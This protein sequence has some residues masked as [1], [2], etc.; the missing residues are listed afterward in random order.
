MSVSNT[1]N[2]GED[3]SPSSQHISVAFDKFLKEYCNGD[4]TYFNRIISI[5]NSS[6]SIPLISSTL[7]S[8]ELP[9]CSDISSTIGLNSNSMST[10]RSM[11]KEKIEFNQF[12][13]AVFRGNED[14]AINFLYNF[15]LVSKFQGKEE[16]D[17]IIESV[18]KTGAIS[19][20][21]CCRIFHIGPV[22]YSSIRQ[23]AQGD[24]YLK[25]QRHNNETSDQFFR[26][27]EKCCPSVRSLACGHPLIFYSNIPRQ[28]TSWNSLFEHYISFEDNGEVP[29]LKYSTFFNYMKAL[30]PNCIVCQVKNPSCSTCVNIRPSN[31][32]VPNYNSTCKQVLYQKFE[33]KRKYFLSKISDGDSLVDGNHG[34]LAN[35]DFGNTDGSAIKGVVTEKGPRKRSRECITAGYSDQKPSNCPI[36]TTSLRRCQGSFKGFESFSRSNCRFSFPWRKYSCSFDTCGFCLQITTENMNQVAHSVFNDSYPQLGSLLFRLHNGQIGS[37]SAKKELES[38]LGSILSLEDSSSHQPIRQH[39][40]SDIDEAMNLLRI[41]LPSDVAEKE[42]VDNNQKKLFVYKLSAMEISLCKSNACG[43]SSQN[44]VEVSRF[45]LEGDLSKISE[46]NWLLKAL[47]LGLSEVENRCL[48]CDGDVVRSYQNFVLPIV[49][50][51]NQ[52][53]YVFRT[54]KERFQGES[55]QDQILIAGTEYRLS[56]CAYIKDLNHFVGI[57]RDFKD[58]ELFYFDGMESSGCMEKLSITLFPFCDIPGIENTIIISAYYIRIDMYVNNI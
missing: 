27:V 5:P 33:E 58:G 2:D 31:R 28:V 30:F 36:C 49:L 43:G 13:T 45:V 41:R 3:I 1:F 17:K 50:K 51:L 20:K 55:I 42:F 22:R 21:L 16:C 8:V 4:I 25:K 37:I 57:G 47:Q 40:F 12:C 10:F 39:Q 52:D 29:K 46:D 18:I 26:F 38:L 32:S 6:S 44:N 54:E 14:E 24:N 53:N 23:M 35:V 56:A 15:L 9:D 11:I 19:Q 7:N 48:Y 34:D